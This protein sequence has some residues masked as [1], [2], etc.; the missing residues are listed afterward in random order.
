M[1]SPD[2]KWIENFKKSALVADGKFRKEVAFQLFYGTD[3]NWYPLGSP[4]NYKEFYNS[5]IEDPT[6][7]DLEELLAY[8]KVA[9]ITLP[10]K[11]VKQHLARQPEDRP[12]LFKKALDI[13]KTLAHYDDRLDVSNPFADNAADIYFLLSVAAGNKTEKRHYRMVQTRMFDDT[14]LPVLYRKLSQLPDGYEDDPI[15]LPP[16]GAYQPKHLPDGQSRHRQIYFYTL[17]R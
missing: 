13:L 9:G 4:D 7:D 11:S 5:V 6:D 14:D 17:L 1:E 10:K 16:A 12:L 15:P 2:K 8:L 3:D